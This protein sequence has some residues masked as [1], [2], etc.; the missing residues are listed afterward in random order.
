MKIWKWLAAIAGVLLFLSFRTKSKTTVQDST[1]EA[2]TKEVETDIKKINE[3]KPVTKYEG[4][5]DLTDIVADY[6]KE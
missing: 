5:K 2:P 1:V 4:N 3:T 6:N